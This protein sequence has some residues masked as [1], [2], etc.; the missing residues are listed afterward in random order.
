MDGVKEM[1]TKTPFVFTMNKQAMIAGFKEGIL[2]MRVGGKT[3]LFIPYYL[4]YGEAG[5]G[6][7]PPKADVIFELEVVKVGK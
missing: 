2:K 3:R 4:A 7:F 6:P 1:M 5:G